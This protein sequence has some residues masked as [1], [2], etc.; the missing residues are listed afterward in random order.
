MYKLFLH[1]RANGLP[2]ASH[3]RQWVQRGTEIKNTATPQ[4]NNKWYIL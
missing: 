3:T 1:N 4:M 2:I